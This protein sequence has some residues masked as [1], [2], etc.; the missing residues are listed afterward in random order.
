MTF[1]NE[2]KMYLFKHDKSK[3]RDIDERVIPLL[4]VINTQD[5]YYTTS[6]CS[7]RVYLWTGT[8]KKNETQWIKVSHELID[9]DF[10]SISESKGL[11]WLRVE[12]FILHVACKDLGAANTLLEKARQIYK[13]SCILTASNKILVEIRGSELVEMPLYKDGKLLYSGE[14]S[15]LMQLVNEKLQKMWE[16]TER[17]RK[18]II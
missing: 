6:S 3:K 11:V 4:K 16:G 14:L 1:P 2:K 18:G 8:G 7:G 9:E 15:W 17:F 10:F 12:A 13:K 5:D